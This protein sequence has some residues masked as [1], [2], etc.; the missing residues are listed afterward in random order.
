MIKAHS[1]PKPKIRINK[2]KAEEIIKDS[3][4]LR[5]KLSKTEINFLWF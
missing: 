4:E 3:D 1:E 5:H 2:K